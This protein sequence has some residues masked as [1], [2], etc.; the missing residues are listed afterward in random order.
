[1]LRM[2]G[3]LPLALISQCVMCIYLHH[4]ITVFSGLEF[5]TF[6]LSSLWAAQMLCSKTL[7][8]F[9]CRDVQLVDGEPLKRFCDCKK[10]MAHHSC[11][12]TWVRMVLQVE[13][14]GE[15]LSPQD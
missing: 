12:L 6:A 9:I 5:G 2:S 14:V 15:L 3:R 8:C 1:M 11:L 7:E 13:V 4:L 10:L